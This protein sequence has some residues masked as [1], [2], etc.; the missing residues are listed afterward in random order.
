MVDGED[1][2]IVVE[3]IMGKRGGSIAPSA[4]VA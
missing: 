3:T 1:R 4:I 2:E